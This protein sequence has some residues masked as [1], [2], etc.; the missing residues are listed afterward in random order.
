MGLDLNW[1]TLA[2]G[3]KKQ[4][5]HRSK[6][7]CLHRFLLTP[8]TFTRYTGTHRR[9]RTSTRSLQ[10]PSISRWTN[11]GENECASP[12]TNFFWHYIFFTRHNSSTIFGWQFYIFFSHLAFGRPSPRLPYLLLS[13][14]FCHILQLL[15]ENRKMLI[16]IKTREIEK[17]RTPLN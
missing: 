16:I 2:K 13:K 9:S 12:L 3:M 5:R 6:P 15:Q 7:P 1:K 17:Q 11:N 4:R 14:R 10:T 8:G